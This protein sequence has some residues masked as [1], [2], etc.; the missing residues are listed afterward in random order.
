MNCAIFIGIGLIVFSGAIIAAD[1]IIAR[2]R[3]LKA[4]RAELADG[5]DDEY[6]ENDN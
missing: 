1:C 6:I 5:L 2:R 4:R 3:T